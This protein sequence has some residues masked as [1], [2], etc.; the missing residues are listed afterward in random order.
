MKSIRDINVKS[1]AVLVRVDYN[2]PVDENLNITDDNRIL[3]TLDLIQYLVEH[4]AKIILVSHMGRPNGKRD[5]KFS[6]ARV[7]ERLSL[8]M[9]RQVLCEDDCVGEQINKKVSQLK[10]GQILLLENLRFH[11]E[12]KEN[13]EVFAKKLADLCNPFRGLP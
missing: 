2:V 3:A 7:A 6:L 9:N 13:S 12:E 10:D 5:L 8:L 11:N 4:Q 1:K